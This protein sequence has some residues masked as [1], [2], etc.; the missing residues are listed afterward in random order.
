MVRH[1]ALPGT[2]KL[3]TEIPKEIRRLHRLNTGYPPPIDQPA[4]AVQGLKSATSTIIRGKFFIA[5]NIRH[6]GAGF[7]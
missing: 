7:L 5:I 6:L 1:S 2:I 3:D 4:A